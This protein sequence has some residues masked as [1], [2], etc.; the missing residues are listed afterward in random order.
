MT[1]ALSKC[2]TVNRILSK[3]LTDGKISDSDEKESYRIQK[4]ILLKGT[5]PK[6]KNKQSSPDIEKIRQEAMHEERMRMQK[7]LLGSIGDVS[8]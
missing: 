6:G 5:L 1:L 4:E 7:K 3:S 8:K 2:D